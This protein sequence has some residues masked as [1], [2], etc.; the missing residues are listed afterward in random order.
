LCY[1]TGRAAEADYGCGMT[2]TWMADKPQLTDPANDMLDALE[3][4][5]RY[6]DSAD[7]EYRSDPFSLFRDGWFKMIQDNINANRLIQYA[8]MDIDI[9]DWSFPPGH[10]FVVDGWKEVGNVRY[11]HMNDG[12]RHWIDVDNKGSLKLHTLTSPSLTLTAPNGGEVW[13]VN[14][15]Q[16]ITLDSGV[17]VAG[18]VLTPRAPNQYHRRTE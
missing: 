15:G 11:V 2:T 10:S 14:S 16:T 18:G 4:H 13:P 12:T 9:W 7:C 1:E 5:F 3:A 6:S 8:Y 17:Q